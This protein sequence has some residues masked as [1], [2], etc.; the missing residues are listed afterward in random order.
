MT[1]G[2]LIQKSGNKE[3]VLKIRNMHKFSKL[4][5][6]IKLNLNFL[7]HLG[8]KN[9]LR[10]IHRMSEP[11]FKDLKSIEIIE[12]TSDGSFQTGKIMS[13][14]LGSAGFKESLQNLI[15]L[16]WKSQSNVS[17]FTKKMLLMILQCRQHQYVTGESD[18]LLSLSP[19]VV[20]E[21]T[22]L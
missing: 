17:R 21:R 15:C 22:Q 8:M 7:H 5:L 3:L 14:Y 4:F 12:L 1:D 2:A 10:Q 18:S 20:H 9:I 6:R 11:T 13:G 19:E 16:Q